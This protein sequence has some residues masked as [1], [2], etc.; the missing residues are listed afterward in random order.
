[1]INTY[2]T[3]LFSILLFIKKLDLITHRNT[4]TQAISYLAGKLYLL[5][6]SLAPARSTVSPLVERSSTI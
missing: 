4:L 6:I 2:N 1:M 3:K 5:N